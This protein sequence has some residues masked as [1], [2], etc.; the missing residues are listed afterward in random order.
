[1]SNFYYIDAKLTAMIPLLQN[2]QNKI[3][4]LCKEHHVLSLFVFGSASR[5]NDFEDGKSDIDFLVEFDPEY[6]HIAF[7]N[8]FDF[9]DGLIKL[10]G[11]NVDLVSSKALKNSYK[12]VQITA[13]Q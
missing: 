10:L 8:Y 3:S 4:E 5:I 1:M 13:N 6:K 12:Y 11:T 7:D 9:R 2:N